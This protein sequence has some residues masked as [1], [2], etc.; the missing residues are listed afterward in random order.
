MQ[1]DISKGKMNSTGPKR[2]HLAIL[3]GGKTHFGYG[4][5]VFRS[6]EKGEGGSS[7][8]QRQS[9]GKSG[10]ERVLR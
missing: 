9:K 2:K 4:K 7:C 10:L 8:P 1:G 5:L 6:K 3:R